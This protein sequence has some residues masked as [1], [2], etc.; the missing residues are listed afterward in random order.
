MAIGND[1]VISNWD[2]RYAAMRLLPYATTDASVAMIRIRRL[3][4]NFGPAQYHSQGFTY[5]E[6]VRNVEPFEIPRLPG[7]IE[8]HVGQAIECMLDG[9]IHD[10][11]SRLRILDHDIARP[12]H[13]P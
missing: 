7:D 6:S 13:D 3:G 10:Y 2:I 9:Q 5:R 11:L 1:A 12:C 4:S 8:C